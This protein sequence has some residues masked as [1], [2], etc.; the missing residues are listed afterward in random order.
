[1]IRKWKNRRLPRG[2]MVEKGK[3]WIRILPNG[4]QFL[5]CFGDADN[6]NNINLAISKLNEYRDEIRNDRFGIERETKRVKFRDAVALFEKK[7]GQTYRYQIPGLILFF[8][9]FWF[10]ELNHVKVAKFRPFRT[11]EKGGGISDSTVNREL[12]ALSVIYY[13]LK[14]LVEL[15]EI[16]PIKLPPIS[17]CKHVERFDERLARR[18]RVLSEDEF[19]RFMTVAHPEV[20][21]VCLAA[22]NTAL[23]RKDLFAITVN[24]VVNDSNLEGMQH[25]TENPYIVPNN[26]NMLQLFQDANG[27]ASVLNS[28]G[29]RE[30]FEKSRDLFLAQ[31]P[32][33]QRNRRF[34]QFR[35]LRR[36][37]LRKV[38][39]KTKDILL[40]KEL[41]GHTNVLTTQLYLG[42]TKAD[43]QKAGSVLEESFSYRIQTAGVSVG[44]EKRQIGFTAENA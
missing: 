23:R 8:G 6:P 40:C 24:N 21:R 16:E 22:L 36:T 30:R 39:D 32:E 5:Q 19:Q 10:D 31:Y 9:D 20:Q 15:K 17:P 4:K 12:T 44:E 25:K 3:V 34:F 43:I 27:T 33:E 14:S 13:K 42:L 7:V 28:T 29:F 26:Q 37:A 2:I 1:M 35:D 18:K 11:S 38:Y 41:A